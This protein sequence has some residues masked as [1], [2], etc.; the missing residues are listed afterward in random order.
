[1]GYRNEC[2]VITI[3]PMS[4]ECVSIS[5]SS[6]EAN[7]G[8][9]SV[10][11]TGGTPPYKYT[12]SGDN[13]GNN[14]H[15]PEVEF[16]PIG[17]YTVTVVDYWGD[18]TATTTCSLATET[19]CNFVGIIQEFILPSQTPTK[20]PTPTPTITP[21]PTR[22]TTLIT[23]GAISGEGAYSNYDYLR[24]PIIIENELTSFTSAYVR[25]FGIR[26][27]LPTG[28]IY[29]DETGT[30]GRGGLYLAIQNTTASGVDDRPVIFGIGF[31]YNPDDVS[32]YDSYSYSLSPGNGE[33]QVFI[34][35]VPASI[36]IVIRVYRD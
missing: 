4:L 28:F 26:T 6:T 2:G 10:S 29:D 31:K 12:W 13:I 8:M 16:V 27:S 21:T 14:N 35:D 22:P 24:G 32:F 5:P 9:V 17:D 11:I 7:D 20:T 18:F 36:T 15:A 30:H 1:M 33:Q 3:F 19:D 25:P 34:A 23:C